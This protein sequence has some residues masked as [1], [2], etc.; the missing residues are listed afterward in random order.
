MSTEAARSDPAP[1]SESD[2][3]SAVPTD[4]APP[5]SP[6]AAPPPDPRVRHGGM[7]PPRDEYRERRCK[8]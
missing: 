8:E 7:R 6:K 3:P 4:A 5:P 1:R 2:L